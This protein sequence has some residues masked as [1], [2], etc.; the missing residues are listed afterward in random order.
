MKKADWYEVPFFLLVMVLAES[1]ALVYL[2]WG[3]LSIYLL[4]GLAVIIWSEARAWV[5]RMMVLMLGLTVSILLAVSLAQ[6]ADF[7]LQHF[8][9]LDLWWFLLC[10]ALAY[11]VGAYLGSLSRWVSMIKTSDLV[12]SGKK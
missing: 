10:L 3:A 12:S 5:L 2:A 4:A 8:G 1:F 6:Q 9:D 11:G 7:L